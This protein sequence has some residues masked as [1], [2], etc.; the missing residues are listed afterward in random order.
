MDAQVVVRTP[1]QIAR[2][3]VADHWAADTTVRQWWA[4]LAASGLA[5]PTWPVGLG[6][7]G[8][9]SP[10]REA[11]R[12]LAD[13]GALTAPAGGIAAMLAAPTILE[14]G[15]PEQVQRYLPAIAW[16]EEAWCQ[17]FSEPGAGSDLA[18]ASTRAEPDGDGGWIV[19]GQKVWNSYA[20]IARRGL[21]LARTDTSGPRHAGLTMFAL[22]MAQPG[23]TA[24]PLRQMN[25]EATFCEVFLDRVRVQPSEVLGGL[26][27]GWRVART[28][29]RHERQGAG[30]NRSGGFLVPS[31]ELAGYLDRPVGEV[32]AELRVGRPAQIGGYAVPARTLIGLARER[33][34]SGHR[35]ALVGYYVQNRVSRMTAQRFRQAGAT[36]P[37][38][39]GPVMKLHTVATCLQSAHLV[40]ALLGAEG[41]L[42]GPDS[43]QDGALVR[44]ALGSPGAR[45][46]GG[47]D[48]IQHNV[49]AE[50]ALGLP[51]DPDPGQIAP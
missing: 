16:G 45:L 51:R 12:V 40:F 2:Q 4:A 3:L 7:L 30:S 36:Y 1:V 48:E 20:D 42:A 25:G 46:G 24:R 14:H 6:G 39:E 9:R 41:M 33:S 44:A 10:D 43:A 5:Q 18:S 19:S 50:R 22:D 17:L 37:G 21:L 47:T 28:T 31:G 11:A 38:A 34:A 27:A 49:L 29:L 35:D 23:V 15:S 26:G 13:A 8:L 32:T